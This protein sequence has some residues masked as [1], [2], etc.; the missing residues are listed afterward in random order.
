MSASTSSLEQVFGLLQVS[1]GSI[2]ARR[3]AAVMILVSTAGAVAVLA[4]MLAMVE[5]LLSVASNTGRPDRVFITSADTDAEMRSSLDADTAS[6]IANV[7]GI[8]RSQDGRVL[9]STD[10]V[11]LAEL[12]EGERR[13]A[14]LPLR[15]INDIGFAVRPEVKLVQGRS[16]QP[17]L[18][19]LI[20]GRMAAAQIPSLQVG[21]TVR[22]RDAQWSVVGMFESGGSLHESEL[23][24]DG[25]TLRTAFNRNQYQSL[26]AQLSSA[27]DFD[28]FVAQ[29]DADGAISVTATRENEHYAE[30]GQGMRR[31]ITFVAY[32]VGAA[33]ALG[34]TLAAINAMYTTV[35]RRTVEIATLRAIGFTSAGI[36]GSV[37]LEALFLGA[38]G[39]LLGIVLASVLV[40]GSVASTVRDGSS[41]LMFTLTVTA[42]IALTGFLWAC[43]MG[44]VGGLLPA[45]RAVRI[46]A[47][48]AL[49]MA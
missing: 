32:F 12:T 45:L 17:G 29:L 5:G 16:F 41:Q 33:M 39:G 37:L 30:Q 3:G 20:V 6:R 40:D 14:R 2:R 18:R 21:G 19:E 4:S 24:T 7:P 42:N 1:L 36:L 31:V 13:V 49:R 34:G 35:R 26:T 43:A 48:S 25:D 9:L 28:E 44:L 15:G 11:V 8:A 46:P 10:T 22:L 23:I 47:A 38:I 27:E